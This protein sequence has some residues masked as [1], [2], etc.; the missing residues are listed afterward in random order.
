MLRFYGFHGS[1]SV[2]PIPNL[3]SVG[4]PWEVGHVLTRG[5]NTSPR[6]IDRLSIALPTLYLCESAVPEVFTGELYPLF[7]VR[8]PARVLAGQHGPFTRSEATRC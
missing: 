1:Q 6:S 8:L 4:G 2:S 7:D 5:M 3:L